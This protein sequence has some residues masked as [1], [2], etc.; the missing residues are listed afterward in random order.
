MP[1]LREKDV[2]YIILEMEIVQFT[3]IDFKDLNLE[4]IR[5]K[6]PLS[7]IDLLN[8]QKYKCERVRKE[9]HISMFL[10]RKYVGEFTLNEYG[11][12]LSKDIYFNISHSGSKVIFVKANVPVG[13]DIE[14]KRE[15]DTKV[16]EYISS[17]EEINEDFYKVWTSKESLSKCLG[18]GLREDIK[19]IPSLP[20]DGI[21]TYKEKTY[22]SHIFE[23]EDYVLSVTI[24]SK[25]DFKLVK[26]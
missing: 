10:K 7:D 12:P 2:F 19:K 17:K 24:E 25:N 23:V 16:Q 6:Y 13:V 4:E 5:E 1:I 14:S 15:I 22:F 9:K 18:T 3:I 8:L 21:K 26:L 11:K 20:F